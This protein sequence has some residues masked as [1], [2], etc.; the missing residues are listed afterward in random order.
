MLQLMLRI[1]SKAALDKWQDGFLA[2][3]GLVQG[4]QGYLIYKCGILAT[5]TRCSV[6]TT[7]I[8]RLKQSCC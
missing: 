4:G 8:S 1:N 5:S 6:H 3:D 7:G 2:I